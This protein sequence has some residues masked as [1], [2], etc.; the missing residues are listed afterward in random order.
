MTTENVDTFKHVPL[1]IQVLGWQ[2]ESKVLK[3]KYQIR[4]TNHKKGQHNMLYLTYLL[5]V[6]LKWIARVMSNI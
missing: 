3:I 4:L 1:K 5:A 2:A 6:I